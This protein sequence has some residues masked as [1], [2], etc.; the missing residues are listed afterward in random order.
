MPNALQLILSPRPP[1]TNTASDAVVQGT[2]LAC[3]ASWAREGIYDYLYERHYVATHAAAQGGKKAALTGAFKFPYNHF[4]ELL[5][6]DCSCTGPPP[7]IHLKQAE[8]FKVLEGELGVEVDGKDYVLTPSDDEYCVPAMSRHRFWP[9]AGG[10]SG[11]MKIQVR[12]D[13]YDG[14]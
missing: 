5:L 1:R 13:A 8:Y 9:E 4:V 11:D 3:E 2:E 6:T 12:V 10:E 7:H 14:G